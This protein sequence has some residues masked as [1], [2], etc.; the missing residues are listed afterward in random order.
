MET[1]R[2]LV[3]RGRAGDE[4][5]FQ[6][7]V[8]RYKGLVYALVHRVVADRTRAEDL[9]LEVFLRVYGGL[10]YFRG[11]A[12]V[13]VWIY[14]TVANTCFRDAARHPASARPGEND[15]GP[16]APVP[17]ARP[18]AERR[19]SDGEWHDRLEQAI[20]RLPPNYRLLIAAHG[21]KNVQLEDVGEALQL[22]PGTVKSHLHRAK[23]QLRR[24]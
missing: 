3:Q 5:A 16:A 2:E 24:L 13:S 4:R 11:E 21:L 6:E 1:D 19:V 7:L 14:R 18:A 10:P 23:R 17:G 15:S 9:A 12:R 8:E 22:P 20:L